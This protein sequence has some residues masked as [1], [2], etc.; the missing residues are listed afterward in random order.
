[1]IYVFVFQRETMVVIGGS[2]SDNPERASTSDEEIHKIITDEVAAAIIEAIP[3]M[4]RSI[5]T[6]LIKTFDER[7]ATVIEASATAPTANLAAMR[8]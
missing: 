3:E 5:K 1:M 8:P 4:F 2:G 6:M 7:Y